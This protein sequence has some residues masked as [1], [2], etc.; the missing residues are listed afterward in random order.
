MDNKMRRK[1]VI[2]TVMGL[3]M[4]LSM[5]AQKISFEKTTV[6]AGA[7]LWKK[8]V[9]A[10]FKFTN[11][12]KSPLFV[13]EV[14]AGCGCLTPTWTTTAVQRGEHGEISVTYDAQL[15]GHFDRDID[16]YTNAEEKPV[17]I[18]MKALVSTAE[19]KTAEE[20]YPYSIDD[21]FLSTNNIEFPDVNLGDSTKVEIEILNNSSEVYTPALM[22]LP[23]YIT[24]EYKPEMIARGRRGKIELT[25]HSDKLQDL[26]LNQTSIYLAR[27]AGDKVGANNEIAVSAVLLPDL[28]F[29]ED[30]AKK[31]TFEISTTELN[32][33][34]LGKK[35]KLT[36]HVRMSNKGSGVLKLNKIQAF[37]QAITVSLKKTELQ[38]NEEVVMKVTV[39]AR[40]LGMSKAEPRVLII[41]NDVK[42]PKEVVNVKFAK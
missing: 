30:F 27:Y 8:P 16:V 24:A 1:Y 41:T 23:P 2:M 36:G 42:R 15:L 28:H 12:D 18:R 35:T 5:G 17:R 3:M 33:G 20:L 11:K 39:D 34:K 21:I 29:A 7:T 32:L 40:F 10:V 25:L 38:P 31:P 19:K 6:N 14:D 26:G 13:R 37:N 4:S 9:T 22:H